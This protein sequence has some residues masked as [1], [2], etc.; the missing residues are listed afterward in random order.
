MKFFIFTCLLA[1]AL[2]KHKMKHS[3]SS[4]ES[5]NMSHEK[6]KQEKNVVIYP[7]KESGEVPTEESASI[8]Q[9]KTKL[10]KENKSILNLLNK[11]AQYHQKFPSPQHFKTV[12]YQ[13][14]MK[15]WNQIK[16]NAYQIIPIVV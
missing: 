14:A 11:M 1:V 3:S 6:F 13:T 15:P 5:V 9:E 4:G 8:S 10:A 12:Q 16:S 2:A 7:I